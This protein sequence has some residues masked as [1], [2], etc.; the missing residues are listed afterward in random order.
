MRVKET[1]YITFSRITSTPPIQ[2][3]ETNGTDLYP[4]CPSS[5]NRRRRDA[6]YNVQLDDLPRY[7]STSIRINDDVSQNVQGL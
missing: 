7:V 3:D 4:T 6:T 2:G 5:N 1:L